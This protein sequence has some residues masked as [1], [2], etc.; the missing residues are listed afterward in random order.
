[1]LLDLAYQHFAYAKRMR[2]SFNE[3]R[4]EQKDN[5]GD[6]MLKQQR[7]QLHQEYNSQ[8]NIEAA[9]VATAL[10]VNP[11]HVAI[12]IH[13]DEK[14]NPVPIVA[15]KGEDS[16]AQK[17]RDAAN[18]NHVPVL[19]NERLARTLLA[20]VEPG[21]VVPR[22]LFDIVA[23][24]ILWATKTSSWVSREQGLLPAYSTLES[25]PPAPGENL[26]VFPNTIDIGKLTHH[27]V[28]EDTDSLS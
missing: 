11:T 20:N 3:V 9:R 13:Y 14:H 19:R 28:L 8:S 2:M 15:A 26:T 24:V 22:E 27:D 21:S 25:P 4:Q 1:M 10:V 5:E 7:R 6:P 18:E 17:M 23:Q 16:L 12:A